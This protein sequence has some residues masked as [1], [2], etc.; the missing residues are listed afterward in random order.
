MLIDEP[1]YVI[2]IIAFHKK[3]CKLKQLQ[4]EVL[5]LCKSTSMQISKTV[6]ERSIYLKYMYDKLQGC[7]SLDG[8]LSINFYYLFLSIQD[9]DFGR[10]TEI[11]SET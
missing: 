2:V 9:Y 11:C 10:N 3:Q 6:K 5:K 7:T 8:T 4:L 1:N